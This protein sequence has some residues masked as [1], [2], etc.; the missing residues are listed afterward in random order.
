MATGKPCHHRRLPN[1]HLVKRHRNYS[2]DEAAS[3]L[4]VH[5]NTVRNWLREGLPALDERRPLLILGRDLFE[6]LTRRRRVNKRPCGAGQIYC[7]RCREPE[8]PV[9]GTIKY[10]PSARGA[11]CLTG[12]CP[13][14]HGSIFR[15]ISAAGLERE[16]VHLNLTLP[17]G[18]KHI[19]ESDQSSANCDFKRE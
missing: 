11:G 19:G 1:P 12:I 18:R 7:V 10:V 6:F 17:E 15:R 14:C 8:R 9:A 3:L 13:R 16:R 4:G 2:V 5:K